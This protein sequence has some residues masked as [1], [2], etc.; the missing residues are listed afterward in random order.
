M[1][2]KVIIIAAI[3]AVLVGISLPSFIRARSTSA[4]NACV[5]NLR[6]INGA[7]Q[8][9]ALENRK[10]TNGTPAWADISPFLRPGLACPGGGVYTFGRVG[11]VPRCSIGGPS[12]SISQ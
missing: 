9:W 7:K 6:Q 3:A 5:N 12:H 10:T 1:R 2:K 8:S 4:T 11:E